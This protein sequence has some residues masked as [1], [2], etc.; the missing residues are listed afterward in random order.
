VQRPPAAAPR[1]IGL[2]RATPGALFVEH[3]DRMDGRVEARDAGEPAIQ[4]LAA[5]EGAVGELAQGVMGERS[6][7][8]RPRTGRPAAGVT[9]AGS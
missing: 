1:R 8:S 7:G 2:G 6:H 9:A 4:Q 5:G 3:G